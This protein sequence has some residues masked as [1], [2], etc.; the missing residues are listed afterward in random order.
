LFLENFILLGLGCQ[1]TDPRDDAKER[2][3]GC[4]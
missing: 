3:D 2:G 4:G 1:A